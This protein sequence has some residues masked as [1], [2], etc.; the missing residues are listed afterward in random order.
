MPTLEERNKA[1]VRRFTEAIESGGA[2]LTER[3]FAESS[4]RRS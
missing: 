3:T 2:E 4:T 1:A